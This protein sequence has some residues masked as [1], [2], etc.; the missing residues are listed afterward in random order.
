MGL[1]PESIRPDKEAA[2]CFR[3]PVLN[4]V[5]SRLN[6][7]TIADVLQPSSLEGL[8]TTV[9][10][11]IS[12]G[13]SLIPCG[14]RHSMGGQQ[15]L[16]NG[17]GID[18]SALD[19]VIRFD[20][21]DGTITIEAGATWIELR[22]YL[23]LQGNQLM[24]R[25][26][27]TGADSLSIGGAVSS[28]IHGRGLEMAPFVED[29][30]SMIVVDSH[31]DIVHCSRQQHSDLFAQVIGGYGLFGI[32]YAVTLRLSPAT[33]FVRHVVL[34]EAR[35]VVSELTRRAAVGHV[36]G[37]F[38]FEIDPESDGF[39]QRG[40]LSSYQPTD[41][42]AD[43]ISPLSESD[44]KG[45]LMLAHT[46]KSQG[47]AAYSAHYQR[48][49]GKIYP[50]SDTQFTTYVNN[51][52]D[53]IDQACGH[54]WRHSEMISEYYV[55]RCDLA[56]FLEKTAQELRSRNTNVIY[57]TV[58]LIQADT[59][60]AL[61]WAREDWACVVINVCVCHDEA[62]IEKA[63]SDF[64]AV[65]DLALK[66]GGSFYLTY[67][68]W[69]TTDQLLAAHPRLL[70]FL[71]AKEVA[72]PHGVFDSDWLRDLTSR[73]FDCQSQAKRSPRLFETSVPDRGSN[74]LACPPS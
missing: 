71:A 56:A 74:H 15:F 34:T 12:C 17:I 57:G 36:Y 35:H 40:I 49:D 62:G 19:K 39:L 54:Q 50:G 14:H 47:F 46:N 65:A 13:H 43:E 29:I 9:R 26:K 1:S 30:Q 55:P 28:N 44:W 25:Q 64:R 22:D 59:E 3:M 8:K 69:F 23:R 32:V 52:H 7:T 68:R 24:I 27:Q 58:R 11:A 41:Q 61:P 5:H 63:S 53:E 21:P 38:Q 72:D 10:N 51:Y 48:T 42:P 18:M 67:H 4:D 66:F 6:Q 33:N 20:Q 73:T 31:G 70:E 37:D 2:A 16:T 60:T 45:L